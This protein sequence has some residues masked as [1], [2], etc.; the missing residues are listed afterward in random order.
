MTCLFSRK[1]VQLL[2]D[3]VIEKIISLLKEQLTAANNETGRLVIEVSLWSYV[4]IPE[5]AQLTNL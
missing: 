1:E 4:D 3:P 5:D 2:F